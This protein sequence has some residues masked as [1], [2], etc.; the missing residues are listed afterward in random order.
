MIDSQLESI[1]P[2]PI[3]YENIA[4]QSVSGLESRFNNIQGRFNKFSKKE[5]LN[6]E[7]F[8]DLLEQYEQHL[9]AGTST[10]DCKVSVEILSFSQCRIEGGYK[11]FVE[12]LIVNKSAC[13]VFEEQGNLI[14][15]IVIRDAK[16]FSNVCFPEVIRSLHSMALNGCLI[17]AEDIELLNKATGRLLN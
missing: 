8:G 6:S 17:N 7:Y 3:V 16:S 11:V 10:F 13:T 5:F 9:K 15:D 12:L 2:V 1:F 4:K 14:I